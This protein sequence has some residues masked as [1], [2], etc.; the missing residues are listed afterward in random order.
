MRA[1]CPSPAPEALSSVS[2]A[3]LASVEAAVAAV[4]LIDEDDS[5]D[6]DLGD[7]FGQEEQ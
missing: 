5:D 4:D 6:A 7:D 3:V 2:D 1:E